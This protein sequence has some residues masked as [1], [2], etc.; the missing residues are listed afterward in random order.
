MKLQLVQGN[1]LEFEGDAI[2]NPANSKL[3]R[4]GGLCG[5]IFKAADKHA[6][7]LERECA[8]FAPVGV[9]N[10]V[11]TK[12]YGLPCKYVIHAVGVKW[13]DGLHGEEILLEA[14]YKNALKE[15][16]ERGFMSV[17]FP[18][19]SSGRYRYP[20]HEAF[21]VAYTAINDFI[22]PGNGNGAR[23]LD[24]VLFVNDTEILDTFKSLS[25]M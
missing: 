1:I 19:I 21:R 10:A 9:G 24:V 11:C 17:A 20:K 16:V 15:S 12:A 25:R 13:I 8:V 4:G 3:H 23:G 7:E 6:P 2:V 22:A 5:A 18:L 14:T